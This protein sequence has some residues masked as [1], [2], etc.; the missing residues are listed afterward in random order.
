L[1]G[2]WLQY[3][4]FRDADLFQANLSN[5]M[6]NLADF[7]EANLRG[8]SFSGAALTQTK[9]ENTS[10]FG[11]NFIGADL[12]YANLRGVSGWDTEATAFTAAC[13]TGVKNAPAG[14][15]AYAKKHGALQ[16]SAKDFKKFQQAFR[17]LV[18]Q[19]VASGSVKLD[20]SLEGKQPTRHALEE[21]AHRALRSI[22]YRK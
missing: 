13:V 5:S 18:K 12:S 17:K 8:A 10:I 22:G 15:I 16:I 2:T 3:A 11:V 7:R 21:L 14:F 20:R 19:A 6:A 9:F 4:N 1:S